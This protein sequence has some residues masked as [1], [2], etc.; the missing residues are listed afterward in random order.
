MNIYDEQ[1]EKV[2]KI[3][4]WETPLL[5]DG[6]HPKGG[7]NLEKAQEIIS[8]LRS[9]LEK[10]IEGDVE[11]EWTGRL[12]AMGVSGV[13]CIKIILALR[14]TILTERAKWKREMMEMIGEDETIEKFW[15]SKKSK[16]ISLVLPGVAVYERNELRREL[17]K[18]LEKI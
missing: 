3:L 15:N 8:S 17:R 1:M 14:Q 13:N 6:K 10:P 9:T 7:C 18:R 4:G 2:A 5:C 12:E 16:E 11:Q